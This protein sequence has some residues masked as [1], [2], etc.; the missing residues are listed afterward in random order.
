MALKSVASSEHASAGQRWRLVFDLVSFLIGIVAGAVTG[1]LAGYLHETETV[2][3]LQERVRLTMLQLD[4]AAL[5]HVQSEGHES[6]FAD[7]H[8][9]LQELQNEIKKLY[10]KHGR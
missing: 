8:S 10:K 6:Q 9:Q 7:L 1:M 4:R 2:G 3:E 5:K